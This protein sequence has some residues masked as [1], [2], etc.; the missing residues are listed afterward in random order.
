MLQHENLGARAG[1]Q[2]DY[3]ARL[4]IQPRYML[5]EPTVLAGGSELTL[6]PLDST[7]TPLRPTPA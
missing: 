7:G 4:G 2:D 1:P 3:T 6:Q 5:L